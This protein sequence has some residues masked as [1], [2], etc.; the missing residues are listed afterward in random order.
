MTR[1]LSESLSQL[2][3]FDNGSIVMGS[4]FMKRSR[5]TRIVT[6]HPKLDRISGGGLRCGE[7]SEWGL[8]LGRGGRELVLNILARAQQ[9]H[10]LGLLLWI[11]PEGELSVYPPAW[12]ARGLDLSRTY[13][14]ITDEVLRDLKAAFV[15]PVFDAIILDTP[16]ALSV[17]DQAYLATRARD[18]HNLILVLRPYL[19]R[20][21][22]GNVWARL[23][24]N[25][26]YDERR[27]EHVID[28]IRGG[29]GGVK[30]DSLRM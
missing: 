15:E 24:L 9:R 25:G 14:A 23:R 21:E 6:G 19:L 17:D 16:R 11:M 18:N 10:E 28:V 20:S 3:A 4:A 29:I 2:P 26:W 22:K 7:L 12:E 8:P 30:P 1:P 5:S 13:F 27:S